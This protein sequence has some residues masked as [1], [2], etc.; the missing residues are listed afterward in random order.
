MGAGCLVP[1][2][3]ADVVAGV[4]NEF[5]T[6]G[7]S[8]VSGMRTTN[9]DGVSVTYGMIMTWRRKESRKDVETEGKVQS[10]EKKFA[11]F[12]TNMWPADAEL[13]SKSG[14]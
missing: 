1:R 7:L 2:K 12:A 13:H 4:L 5:A 10:P 6:G 3:N 9:A 8:A 11:G 14:V